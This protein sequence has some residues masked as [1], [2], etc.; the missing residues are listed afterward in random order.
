VK[1]RVVTSLEYGIRSVSYKCT[2]FASSKTFMMKVPFLVVYFC[3]G[4]RY[5]MDTNIAGELS[6]IFPE[7]FTYVFD[8]YLSNPRRIP[9]S[10]VPFTQLS[11]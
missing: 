4:V 9:T 8:E 7:Q 1:C 5:C 2:L 3:V 11:F 10:S 6:A